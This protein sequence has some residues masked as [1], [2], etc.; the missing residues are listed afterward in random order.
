MKDGKIYDSFSV[1]P[2][3]LHDLRDPPEKLVLAYVPNTTLVARIVNRSAALM[4]IT[5]TPGTIHLYT[6]K[7]ACKLE[8]ALEVFVSTFG[9]CKIFILHAPP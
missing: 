9:V 3:L 1:T 8:I 6:Q 7:H 5:I 2:N 4:G